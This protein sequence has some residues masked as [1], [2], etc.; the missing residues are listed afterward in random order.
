MQASDVK[1]AED[2]IQ[3]I[4]DRDLDYIKVGLFDTDGVMRGKYM[5]RDKFISAL[6]GGFGFCDVVLGW[7]SNDQLYDN[8]SFTGWHT[9]YP[10]APV[11]ILP[12]TCREL[13]MEDQRSVLFLA[14]F[15]EPADSVCARGL[16][17]RVLD[18]A[19][20]HGYSVKSACE[21]EFFLFDEDSESVREKGYRDLKPI[22]P[23]FFGYSMLRNSVYAEFYHDLLET[24]TLM[25][26]PI[27]GLHT[28]TGPGVL[29][30]ALGVDDAL[31]AADK[32][33]LFK[34]FT[35]VLAQRNGWMATFMAKWSPD[36]PGQS[37]HIHV[38]LGHD[39]RGAVFFDENKPD[40]ISDEMR[41]F[42]GGPQGLMPELLSMIACTVNSYSPDFGRRQRRHGVLRTGHAPFARLAA[43][44]RRSGSSTGLQRQTSIRIS[45]W[46]RLSALVSGALKTRSNR[47][48][49][50][51]GMP[52][53]RRSRQ[54]VVF[55]QPCLKRRD[56]LRNPRLPV[57]CSG[58]PLWNIMLPPVN[59]KSGSSAKRL[60][61]GK[62]N[63]TSKLSDLSTR[64]L[65]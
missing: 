62:W 42:I 28:E 54:S 19:A 60:P 32:A 59:G 52:M 39:E 36:W 2:A 61:A 18:R 8:T 34:T 48:R 6:K 65:S 43:S 24:C 13:P 7:D 45:R 26:M 49:Q 33:A 44:P 53:R 5:S 38:S 37:G 15:A 4:E 11:R 29:E 30:A 57:I 46:R 9:A 3:L 31:R 25:D 64:L 41:W 22:S 20:G 63:V 47:M 56:D 23:G 16:L 40:N 12:E 14:E 27:E 55:R 50:S 51:R 58:M 1:T 17:R 21:F 35:K 10:D